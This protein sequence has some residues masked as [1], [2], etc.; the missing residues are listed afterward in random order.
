M[1]HIEI[2]S[3][4]SWQC[5]VLECENSAEINFTHEQAEIALCKECAR[6]LANEIME[7]TES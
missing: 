5:S 3:D 1:K 4:S 7:V 6:E 2:V